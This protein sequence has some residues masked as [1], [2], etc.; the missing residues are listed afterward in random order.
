MRLLEQAMD[1]VFGWFI[2]LG[3]DIRGGGGVQ[4]KLESGG[5]FVCIDPRNLTA[6]YQKWPYLKPESLF[7]RPIILGI[8]PLVFGG[9]DPVSTAASCRHTTDENGI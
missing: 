8:Q 1:W 3:V 6:R 2:C 5:N 7:R 9:V 4:K